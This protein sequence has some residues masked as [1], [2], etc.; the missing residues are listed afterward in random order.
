[1][2]GH[3]L[4]LK[5]TFAMTMEISFSARLL[6][7]LLLLFGCS[8]QRGIPKGMQELDASVENGAAGASGSGGTAG[9]NGIVPDSG[10]ETTGND[11]AE[12]AMTP[13]CTLNERHCANGGVE[14][15]QATGWKQVMACPA[16]CIGS[17][18]TECKPDAKQCKGTQP[19]VCSTK[20]TWMSAGQACDTG[21][22]MTTG[23]CNGCPDVGK[24]TCTGKQVFKCSSEKLWVKDVVCSATQ[25]CIQGACTACDPGVSAT[26]CET[27]QVLEC[28]TDGQWKQK[29]TCPKG[30]VS[31]TTDCRIC[32][33]NTEK[34]CAAGGGAVQKC[35]AS[36]T[37]W[38]TDMTCAAPANGTPKCANA[39]CAGFDCNGGFAKCNDGTCRVECP[40]IIGLGDL[41]GGEFW[42]TATGIDMTGQV[43]IGYS[44]TGSG[45]RA[46]KWSKLTGIAQLQLPNNGMSDSSATAVNADGS[47]VVGVDAPAGTGTRALGW[48]PNPFAIAT[49]GGKGLDYRAVGVSADGQKYLISELGDQPAVTSM[50]TAGIGLK[51]VMNG[52]ALGMSDDTSVIAVN[53]DTGCANTNQGVP[54]KMPDGRC[55]YATSLTRDGKYLYGEGDAWPELLRWKVGTSSLDRFVLPPGVTKNY[56]ASASADGAVVVGKAYRETGSFYFLWTA[57]LGLVNFAE[58]LVSKGISLAGWSGVSPFRVS[59]DGK[60]VVGV[61]LNGSQSSEAIKVVL[62]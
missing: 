9:A 13:T 21:C 20:G 52:S 33:P 57:Q 34:Q 28:G 38:V 51:F 39:V 19:E 37:A 15:C 29:T 1:M 23:L 48:A 27:D 5:R 6:V 36:G 18:C 2:R 35:N 7:P 46:F 59:G 16:F 55:F 24:T 61:A 17:S 56:Y 26:K 22:N 42:S 54:P 10:I 41:P 60:V 14:E 44:N 31:G 4:S 58:Y 30:C 11:A 45:D 25:G 32:T 43:V 3:L 40:G 50:V 49:S 53:D 62:P 8:T 12:Q 47:V